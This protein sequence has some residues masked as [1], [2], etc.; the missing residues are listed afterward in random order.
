M[1]LNVSSYLQNTTIKYGKNKTIKIIRR[2]K[3]TRRKEE[4]KRKIRLGRHRHSKIY[5]KVV[6]SKV[7]DKRIPNIQ[8]TSIVRQ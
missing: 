3:I 7:I 6:N 8:K 1:P 5:Q 4:R 2:Y